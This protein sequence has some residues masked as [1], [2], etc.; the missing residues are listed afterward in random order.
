MHTDQFGLTITAASDAAVTAFD[1]TVGGYLAFD[2]DTGLYLKETLEADPEMV[3]GHCLKGY[4]FHLMGLPVLLARAKKELAT[5]EAAADRAN[6]RERLHLTALRAW[7]ASDLDGANVAWEAILLD[8]PR[9]IVALKLA[10]YSHL[11]L[12]R[13][14]AMRDSVARVLGAWDAAEPGYGYVLS[15]RA[16]GLEEAGD[17][18]AAEAAGRRAT[19]LNPKDLW[20]VHAVTHVMEMQDRNREGIAWI[21]GLEPHWQACNNF[22][23]HLSWH[24]AL[25]RLE[26]GQLDAVL[27]IYDD[28]LWDPASDEYLD[29]CNDTSLLLRLELAG[30]DVGDRWQALA[31]KVKG[32]THD[33]ILA[34]I[35]THF[36]MALAVA[37]DGTAAREMLQSMAAYGADDGGT[38]GPLTAEIGRPIAEALVAHRAGDYGRCVDLLQPIRYRI[39]RIGGSH[40]QRDVFAQLLIDAALRAGRLNL[41]RALL[42]ERTAEKPDNPWSWRRYGEAL[43][44]LGEA[45]AAIAAEQK[46]AALLSA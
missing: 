3:M 7:C 34:F 27:A 17:Y 21:D 42:A 37:G 14:R 44:R 23:F 8:H 31:D 2:R 11:Y 38:N 32:R 26:L 20:G 18:P 35:D 46:A 1:K 5:A 12:G 13:S 45:P 25:M 15:M 33:H 43:R 9:D 10:H 30:A 28:E 6:D 41:A 36:M 19:E 24:R 22:R 16:F 40:A 29:L 39:H 4:F